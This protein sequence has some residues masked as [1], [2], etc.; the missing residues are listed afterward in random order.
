MSRFSVR[1]RKVISGFAVA[2]VTASMLAGSY[3]GVGI[4]V[5]ALWGAVIAIGT[6][7]NVRA[8]RKWEASLYD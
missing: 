5:Y 2:G 1:Q 4:Y 7:R 3:Y 8:H 6:V